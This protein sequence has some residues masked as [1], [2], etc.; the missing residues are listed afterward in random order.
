MGKIGSVIV[1]FGLSMGFAYASRQTSIDTIEVN[2]DKTVYLLFDSK[3]VTV[4]IGNGEEVIETH[5]DKKVLLKAKVENFKY[6]TN[7]L[8]E[9]ETAIFSFNIRYSSSPSRLLIMCPDSKAFSVKKLSGYE[10]EKQQKDSRNASKKEEPISYDKLQEYIK[11]VES[12]T[13]N[14]S[15]IG[16]VKGKMSFYLKGLYIQDDY[17]FANVFLDNR[18]SLAYDVSHFSFLV[19][20][21][22]GRVKQAAVQEDIKEPFYTTEQNRIEGKSSGNMVVVF[23]KFTISGDKKLYMDVWES[24]GDRYVVFP[25]D[26]KTFSNMQYLK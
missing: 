16:I 13:G 18:S 3:V 24:N 1:L 2:F 15:D 19:R 8:I 6:E 11:L 7:I 5:E 26:S 22:K 25:V 9:T 20:N 10:K 21:G 17:I 14:I 4:D 12:T 23:K